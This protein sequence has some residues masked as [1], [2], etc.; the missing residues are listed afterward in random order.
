MFVLSRPCVNQL[1]KVSMCCTEPIKNNDKL[2]AIF[3]KFGE[4]VNKLNDGDNLAWIK[5]EPDCIRDARKMFPYGFMPRLP[6]T[7]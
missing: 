4:S 3:R 1:V 6:L 7:C 2:I 5:D